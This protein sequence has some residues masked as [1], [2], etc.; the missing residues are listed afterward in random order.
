MADEKMY[1]RGMGMRISPWLVLAGLALTTMPS[2]ADTLFETYFAKAADGKP[3]YARRYDA[4]HLAT[5][6]RQTIAAIEVDFE[7]R[8]PDGAVNTAEHFELG[9][10]A[11]PRGA[12]EW[13][14]NAGVCTLSGQAFTCHLEGD[15]GE[16]T[17]RPQPNGALRLEVARGIAIEGGKGFLQFGGRRSDDNVFVLPPAERRICDAA[18]PG[19]LE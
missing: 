12:T 6:P 19:P 15:G 16:F 3:C 2:H 13:F 11:Q 7:T 1:G 17:L 18:L 8:L 14:T 4:Q 10:G 9:F 5:H